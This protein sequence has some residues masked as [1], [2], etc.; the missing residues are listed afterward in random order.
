MAGSWPNLLVVEG[1]LF[2]SMCTWVRTRLRRP[3]IF[4]SKA[5]K[6]ATLVSGLQSFC[7]MDCEVL[8]RYPLERAGQIASVQYFL[9]EH[10]AG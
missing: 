3:P 2:S 8:M 7:D 5:K 4:I 9:A 1:Y 6:E 10:T